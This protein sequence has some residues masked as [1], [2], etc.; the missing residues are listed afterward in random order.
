MT[1]GSCSENPNSPEGFQQNILKGKVKERHPS[2]CDQLV[3]NSLID[4]EVTR[5]CHRGKCYQSIGT[6]K[7]GGYMPMILQQLISY[8]WWGSQH[9]WKN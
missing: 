2:M 8:V 7:S 3:H 6:R 9:L 5:P 1:C 4:G